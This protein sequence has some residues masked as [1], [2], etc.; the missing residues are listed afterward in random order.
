M[1]LGSPEHVPHA[2]PASCREPVKKGSI[3]RAGET[4]WEREGK[5]SQRMNHVGRVVSTWI[6]RVHVKLVHLGSARCSLLRTP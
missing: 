4:A 2:A 6:L 3:I 5:E 1:L